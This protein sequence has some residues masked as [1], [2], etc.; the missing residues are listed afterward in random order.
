MKT[1]NINLFENTSEILKVIAHPIR[2]GIIHL[3]SEEDQLSVTQIYK[4][5]K[6]EQATASHHLRILKDKQIVCVQRNG[7]SAFYSLNCKEIGNI[8]NLMFTF[9]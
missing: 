8:V 5:L 2:I 4:Y 3:L 7:K 6:I 9:F 1:F